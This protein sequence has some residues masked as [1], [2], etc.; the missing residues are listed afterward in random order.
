MNPEAYDQTPFILKLDVRFLV[1]S[2]SS[3]YNLIPSYVEYIYS[4]WFSNI[5]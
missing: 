1:K 5:Y 4:F 2:L 3:I